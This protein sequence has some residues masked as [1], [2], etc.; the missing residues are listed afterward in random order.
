MAPSTSLV[1]LLLLGLSQAVPLQKEEHKK[2]GRRHGRHVGHHHEHDDKKQKEHH[3]DI[4]TRILSANNGSDELLLE[5]DMM[6]PK[7]RNA[8][9]C[10]YN[11]CLWRKSSKGLVVVPYVIGNEYAGY[12]KQTIQGAMMAFAAHT[13]IRFVPRTNEKDFIMI[14]SKT[15]CYSELGRIGGMQELS[16]NKGGCVYGGIAQHEL[17][18]ALGFQHEQT[19]SDRDSHIRI[20]W[21][22]IIPATAY[23]FFKHDTNNLNTPYDY[24]SIMHYGRDAF[25]IAY[26]RDSMT[27]IPNPN[28][29]IGQRNGLSYWDIKRINILYK[30]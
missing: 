20:N 16:L 9:K 28:A 22:N 29:Q 6:I 26:G 7:T 2:E 10:L 12:E 24:G 17:N 27:P 3:V 11:S 18:H 15:G 1:L 5:G 30:C 25:S 19:R 21:Q 8:M 4:T 23:N 13:C 14:H